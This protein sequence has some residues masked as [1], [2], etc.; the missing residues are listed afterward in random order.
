MDAQSSNQSHDSKLLNARGQGI[1]YIAE[2]HPDFETTRGKRFIGHWEVDIVG[3]FSF[4]EG[5]GW[6]EVEEAL[7]WGRRRA[8]VIILRVHP[9]DPIIYSAGSQQPSDAHLPEWIPDQSD[10]F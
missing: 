1:V 9:L 6:M 4:E 2:Q 5:P 7:E 3:R 8:S 10:D